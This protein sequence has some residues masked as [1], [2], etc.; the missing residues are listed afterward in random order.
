[1]KE[2]GLSTS[3]HFYASE[4]IRLVKRENGSAFA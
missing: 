1:M 4:W 2:A 3:L